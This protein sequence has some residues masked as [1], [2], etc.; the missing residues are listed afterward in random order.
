MTIYGSVL[1]GA[2]SIA[3][4]AWRTERLTEQAKQRIRVFDWWRAHGK[5]SSLAARHFGLGRMTLYRWLQRFQKQGITGFNEYS[6]RPRNL[7]GATTPWDVTKRTVELRLQYPAWSKHKIRSLLQR[8]G[9]MTSVSTVGRILKRKGL[10]DK[11]K[12]QKR[13]RAALHPRARFPRGLRVCEAGDM[14][15]I[16]TKYIMLP[17]GKKYYQFTAIDV[18]SKQRVLR[19]YPSQSSRN[20]VLFL[21]ECLAS[22]PFLVKAIQTDNGAPF[23]KEFEKRC[24][25]LGLPHY[26]TY[27][28]SPKQNSYVEISHGA[29]EREFYQQGNTYLF[30]ET[31][32][33]KLKEWEVTWNTVRPHASLNYLTPQEYLEKLKQ[34]RLPT[35]DTI[36]L[37]A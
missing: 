31:M 10:I 30:L 13:R 12:S 35:R 4:G 1:P 8:E 25:E 28:R 17:G 16:D 2:R 3:L 20:G 21:G 15:Q 36:V 5:N 23:L 32:R 33:A 19:V 14:I 24:Q 29:D 26:F 37:Q 6:R 34:G 11:K 9:M 7:R 18:L 27:P 22:F